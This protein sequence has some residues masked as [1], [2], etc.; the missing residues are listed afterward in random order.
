MSLEL[1]RP[2]SP[3]KRFAQRF[4]YSSLD[5]IAIQ[6]LGFGRSPVPPQS[7]PM[8]R[9]PSGA[10]A[11]TLPPAPAGILPP[12]AHSSPSQKR[13]APESPSRQRPRSPQ[14][15]SRDFSEVHDEPAYKRSRG[16]S[17]R[18]FPQAPP[19]PTLPVYGQNQPRFNQPM[20]ERGKERSPM[21]PPMPLSQPQPP[22][23]R[24]DRQVSGGPPPIHGAG[25][26]FPS[27]PPPTL[28]PPGVAANA[29]GGEGFDRSGLTRP[30][31]WFMSTLPNSRYFDGPV[32][33][34][35]DIMGLFGNIDARGV[36]IGPGP[37]PS[38]PPPP[39]RAPMPPVQGGYGGPPPPQPQRAYP[40][41]PRYGHGA[42]PPPPPQMYGGRRY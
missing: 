17:P 22:M 23:Y 33:R 14:R 5:E 3:L 29:R 24:H 19:A 16:P 39:Q 31:A 26:S 21:P 11:P 4:I 38:M 2:D 10:P 13:P 36:G 18:R 25:P 15:G 40:G 6:D 1:T 32:F 7:G 42:P 35:D 12:A 28:A 30:L 20:G 27:A 41:D 9:L 8:P 34:P 37:A